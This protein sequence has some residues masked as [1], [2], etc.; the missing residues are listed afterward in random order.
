MHGRGGVAEFLELSG[1]GGDVA[2]VVEGVGVLVATNEAEGVAGEK[3]E[4]GVARAASQYRHGEGA[5]LKGA[6]EVVVVGGAGVARIEPVEDGEV[7]EGLVHDGDDGGLLG[8]E[9]GRCCGAL[10][11]CSARGVVAGGELFLGCLGGLGGVVVGLGDGEV[12]HHD[13]E[14][15]NPTA[16]YVR[17]DG[18]PVVEGDLER[19]GDLVVVEPALDSISAR[20][21][22][23][24]GYRCCHEVPTPARHE[25][26]GGRGDRFERWVHT[27]DARSRMRFLCH[28]ERRTRSV[29]SRRIPLGRSTAHRQHR[30]PHE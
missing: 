29:R 22:E 7:G 24:D 26:E 17:I 15:R 28:S 25:R 11:G 6:G 5:A 3:L 19:V 27:A 14:R 13:G 1:E 16:R 8:V 2:E 20:D 30:W 10:G 18:L 4:L 21:C 9:S 23:H 12:L